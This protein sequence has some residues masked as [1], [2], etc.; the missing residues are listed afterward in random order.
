MNT[1]TFTSILHFSLTPTP[2]ILTKLQTF[3]QRQIILI[4]I[5]IKTYAVVIYKPV[6]LLHNVFPLQSLFNSFVADIL[7]VNKY[8]V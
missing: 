2:K 5:C 4:K 8:V 1:K 7:I 3:H 6:L